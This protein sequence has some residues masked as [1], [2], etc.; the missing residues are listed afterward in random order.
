MVHRRHVR[1]HRTGPPDACSGC[2]KT[3]TS[4]LNVSRRPMAR[5]RRIRLMAGNPVTSWPGDAPER[6]ISAG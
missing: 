1:G 4:W 2:P 3:A 6:E 5:T